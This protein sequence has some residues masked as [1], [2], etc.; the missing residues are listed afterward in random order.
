M[1]SV[2]NQ[3][4]HRQKSLNDTKLKLIM[5]IQLEFDML[6]IN[7]IQS[8]GLQFGVIESLI[9]RKIGSFETKR[10]C[11]KLSLTEDSKLEFAHMVEI[12]TDLFTQDLDDIIIQGFNKLDITN[13]G[14][15]SVIILKQALL[16]N[17]N[18]HV[19]VPLKMVNKRLIKEL[20]DN[21]RCDT[22]NKAN[23]LTY[24][25]TVLFD[26]DKKSKSFELYELRAAQ[27]QSIHMRA[28]SGPVA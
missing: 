1:A 3:V 13:D 15:V 10:L 7:E 6:G 17:N 14:Q 28:E 19:Q 5:S 16:L 27:T 20:E 24:F 12:F 23:F 4:V 18:S 9:S 2:I 22:F 8:E 26:D 21:H 11:S 25:K